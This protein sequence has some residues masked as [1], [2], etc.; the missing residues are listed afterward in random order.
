M[1]FV[2]DQFENIHFSGIGGIGMSALARMFLSKN[3][4]VSG[5]DQSKTKITESLSKEGATIFYEESRGNINEYCDALIYTPALSGDHPELVEAAERN[6]P[7]FSY[8]EALGFVSKEI[9]TIAVS[10][11][12]GKTTTTAMIA[13]I[14]K[15]AG[16]DPTVIVGSLLKDW[17][18][19][20]GGSN[21]LAG[22]GKY[23]VVEACEYKR[24]F[25]HL[26][27]DIL[28]ITN[29]EED[30]LDY[31]KD[32]SDIQEAFGQI[33][34]KVSPKGAVVCADKD[35][36]VRPILKLSKAPVYDYKEIDIKKGSLNVPGEHNRL[37]ALAATTAT[38]V[39]GVPSKKAVSIL[40]S[41]KG[42][43]RRFEYKGKTSKGAL[44]YDDYAHHPS[45]ISATIN[46]ARD[47]FPASNIVVVF[48]PHLYSRT[49]AFFEEIVNSL[50]KADKVIMV[51]VYQA[52]KENHT[53]TPSSSQIAKA[54]KRKGV[55]AFSV[56]SLERSASLAFDISGSEDVV[57][58]MGAGDIYTATERL[59]E[60]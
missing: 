9:F 26:H 23:F 54:L 52:R 27:P 2:L 43:W 10:G 57:V 34:S 59:L 56:R 48:Q 45:E 41:F 19:G 14:L 35:E 6:I 60:K 31:Y 24:S 32:L 51:P 21:F 42:T 36:K 8:P 38:S 50:A 44:V 11:T 25:N 16:M 18:E 53:P 33:I 39:L 22:S 37:N 40:G 15:E 47:S 17:G 4:N 28:V 58:M 55:N 49:E 30:H 29:I 1:S 46:A 20:D 5:S 13:H 3:I 12:H 7:V